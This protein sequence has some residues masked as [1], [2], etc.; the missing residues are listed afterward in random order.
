MVVDQED[1]AANA[2]IELHDAES[3]KLIRTL[4]TEWQGVTAMTFTQQGTLIASGGALTSGTEWPSLRQPVLPGF[5]PKGTK[6]I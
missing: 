2:H 6:F 1:Q 4:N 5:Q 3:G